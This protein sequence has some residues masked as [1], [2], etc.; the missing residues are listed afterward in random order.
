M[1]GV[2]N[3]E[4]VSISASWQCW[5]L[6]RKLSYEVKGKERSPGTMALGKRKMSA[7]NIEEAV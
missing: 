6:L 4:I 5:K 7:K 3:L 2:I 1:S